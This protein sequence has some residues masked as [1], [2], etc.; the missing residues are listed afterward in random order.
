[1]NNLQNEK[2][3]AARTKVNAATQI[4][5]NAQTD[6]RMRTTD[7]KTFLKARA[8]YDAAEAEFDIA[9]AE[10]ENQSQNND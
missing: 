1:M 8:I 10:A 5:H 9:Y 2:Y 4:W 3:E 7:A 6:F